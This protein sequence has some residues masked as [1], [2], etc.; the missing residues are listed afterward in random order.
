MSGYPRNV[1]K[2]LSDEKVGGIWKGNV[3]TCVLY[4]LDVKM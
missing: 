2:V 1:R 3:K 4:Y